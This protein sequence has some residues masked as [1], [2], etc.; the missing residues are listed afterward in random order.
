RGRAFQ[1]IRLARMV[2]GVGDAL[3]RATSSDP[4]RVIAHAGVREDGY[5]TAMLL[6]ADDHRNA[7]GTLT[8]FDSAGEGEVYRYAPHGPGSRNPQLQG[9]EPLEF[10]DGEATLEVPWRTMAVAVAPRR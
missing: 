6:N 1:G 7:D 9:P 5:V 10:V 8:G 4:V 3:V 2:A